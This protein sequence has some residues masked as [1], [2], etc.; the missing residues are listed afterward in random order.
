MG[1]TAVNAPSK[2]EHAYE[3]I[4]ARIVDGRYSPGHRLVLDR[5]A[6]ELDIS[7]VPV[8]EAVRRLEA[9]R[10]VEFSRNVGARVSGI[11]PEQYAHAMQTL[12]IVEGAATALAGP[13]L[14]GAD[15]A[16]AR[17][18]NDRMRAL[19]PALDPVA[20]TALNNDFHRALFRR[21]PNP[22]LGEL[23]ESSW[24]RLAVIRRST[25]EHV[26]ARAAGSVAEHDRL[27]TLIT[28]GADATEIESCAR[29]HR[30]AT[31]A[32]YLNPETD[33]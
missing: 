17:A 30:L 15:L 8:R 13:L 18:V 28:D 20:F 1:R 26:P 3:T 16:E 14:T 9:E 12:A 27:L 5:L 10:F 7:P 33:A 23:V 29:Q 32:T 31:L 25:F 24:S 6:R 21:C 4:K 2:S 11:D 22:L 19:L